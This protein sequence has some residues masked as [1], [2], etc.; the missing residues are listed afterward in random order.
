MKKVFLSLALVLLSFACGPVP[1]E[2]EA[3][4]SLGSPDPMSRA[5]AANFVRA[6][7]NF[8]TKS[9]TGLGSSVLTLDNV[10]RSVNLSSISI[11][12]SSKFVRI[13]SQSFLY[14]NNAVAKRY[15]RVDFFSDNSCASL[16]NQHYLEWY[17]F[18][19]TAVNTVYIFNTDA[20]DLYTPVGL[21]YYKGTLNGG[22]ITSVTI[23]PLA[24]Y[25]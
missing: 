5:C 21:I 16:T 22:S 1:E 19:A 3:T 25:D 4:S 11:P 20:I 18:N 7:P 15:T 12:T 8:C 9:N 17:E 24:Y 6:A 14:S 13:L 2:V 10:C 23:Y